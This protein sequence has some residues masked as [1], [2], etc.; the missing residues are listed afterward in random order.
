VGWRGKAALQ[1]QQKEGP[2]RLEVLKAM[3]VEIKVATVNIGPWG[4]RD[5]IF[6]GKLPSLQTSMAPMWHILSILK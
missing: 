5:L 3:V 2:T 4:P 6:G 1:T